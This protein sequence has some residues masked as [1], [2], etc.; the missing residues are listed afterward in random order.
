M[1]M[2]LQDTQVYFYSVPWPL[3]WVLLFIFSYQFNAHAVSN[4][5][6]TDLDSSRVAAKPPTVTQ[7]IHLRHEDLD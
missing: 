6:D 4:L 7:V 1:G 5:L 2:W 3:W